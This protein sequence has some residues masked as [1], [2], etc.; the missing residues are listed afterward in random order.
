MKKFLTFV[1]VILCTF[2][3]ASTSLADVTACIPAAIDNNGVQTY[4]WDLRDTE[5]DGGDVTGNYC[6]TIS[7]WVFGVKFTP[8]DITDSV[9]VG[10]YQ[11]LDNWDVEIEDQYGYDILD[12]IGT[13]VT[14]VPTGTR[15]YRTPVT[16]DSSG[17]N[18]GYIYLSGAKLRAVVTNMG[19]NNA[20]RIEISIKVQD[21]V[22]TGR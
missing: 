1:F 5:S 3:I 16:T 22:R 17:N 15:Q 9:I 13:N 11:P 21:A 20:A 6:P 2:F 19:N 10:D 4:R 7:G 8:D 18:V 14:N 12:G